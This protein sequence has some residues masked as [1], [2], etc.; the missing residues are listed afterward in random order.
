[1]NSL[2]LELTDGQLTMLADEVAKRLQKKPGP[3]Q[4]FTVE[5]FAK[6]LRVSRDTVYNRIKTGE[7][8]CVPGMR[9]K[10]IYA[11]EL[12]RLLTP[13]HGGDGK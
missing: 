4:P 3:D 10:L 1:M 7:I 11:T 8:R 12:A 6:K 2:F 5:E 9:N 13:D